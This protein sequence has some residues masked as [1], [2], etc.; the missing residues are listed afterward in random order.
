VGYEVPTA[1]VIKIS[2]FWDMTF[3]GLLG[4]VTQKTELF[5]IELVYFG[6]KPPKTACNC[7]VRERIVEHCTKFEKN[8]NNLTNISKQHT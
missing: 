3:N 6:F 5:L 1:V 7:P 2:A 4:G 8:V